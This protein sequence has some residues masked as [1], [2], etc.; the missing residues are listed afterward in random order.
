MTAGGREECPTL[1]VDMGDG[2]G[3]EGRE[4]ER[5]DAAK[6]DDEPSRRRSM[7][8]SRSI[9]VVVS[10]MASAKYQVQAVVK[11]AVVRVRWNREG[12][13]DGGEQ[14]RLDAFGLGF[15]GQKFTRV[16][17]RCGGCRRGRWR[18]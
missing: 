9:S 6:M 5:E 18:R 2:L 10:A 8:E 4:E 12:W 13:T 3:R 17:G 14:G 1:S 15:S 7:T 11:R 16:G